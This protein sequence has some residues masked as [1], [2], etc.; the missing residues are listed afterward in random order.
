MYSPIPTCPT[1][2]EKIE[3]ADNNV[4]IKQIKLPSEMRLNAQKGR[5]HYEFVGDEDDELQVNGPGLLQRLLIILM[6]SQRTSVASSS[7]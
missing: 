3:E 1:K 6:Q 7:S 2:H 5:G 4:S